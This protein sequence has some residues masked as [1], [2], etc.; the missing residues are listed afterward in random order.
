M[1]SSSGLPSSTPYP[2]AEAEDEGPPALGVTPRKAPNPAT[3][4]RVC[5]FGCL[6]EASKSVQ[7]LF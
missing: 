4:Y 5:Y 1:G 6:N 7:V 2:N 3:F